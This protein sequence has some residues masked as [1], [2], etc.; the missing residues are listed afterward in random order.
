M[1]PEF[2]AFIHNDTWEI[3]ESPNDANII[4]NKWVYIVKLLPNKFL[5]KYKDWVVAKG[6]NQTT[7]IDYSKIFNPVVK[8]TTIRV[9]LTIALTYDW[10]II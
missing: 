6:Y 9:V 3:F 2:D 8:P 5:D 4:T 10:S 7:G 1:Q